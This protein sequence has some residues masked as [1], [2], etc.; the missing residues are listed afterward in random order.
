M[1]SP[2]RTKLTKD[3][4]TPVIP[5]MQESLRSALCAY[6][7]DSGRT[8]IGKLADLLETQMMHTLDRY[9]LSCLEILEV[10]R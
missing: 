8:I 3:M 1:E 4:T 9:M 5:V 10:K 2:V 7:Q 6:E